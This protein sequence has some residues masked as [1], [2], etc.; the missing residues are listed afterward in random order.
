MPP[1]RDRPESRPAQPI[2]SLT[3]REE[4]VLLAVAKGWTNTEIATELF[5]SLSTVKTLLASL[6]SK[7]SA[8]NR[9]EIAMWPTRRAEFGAELA[10]RTQQVNSSTT[11]DFGSPPPWGR[12]SSNI[13]P[14]RPAVQGS[15]ARSVDGGRD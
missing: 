8:R 13:H 6:M 14:T 4:E 15:A 1:S 11:S 5:I 7:L 9:V 12:A 2:D 3:D 10:P